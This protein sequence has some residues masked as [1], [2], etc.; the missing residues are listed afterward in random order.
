[1]SRILVIV[2]SPAKAIKIQKILGKNYIVKSSYGHIR[3]LDNKKF[4]SLGIDVN[5]NF[6]PHYINIKL[7]TKNINELKKYVKET[8]ETILAS[9]EDREGEAIAWHLA[10]VL[11]L[12]INKTKRICFNEITKPALLNAINNPKLINIDLVKAQKTRQI[13]DKLVGYSISPILCQ[14]IQKSL[15]AGRVQSVANRL[16]VER[17]NEINNFKSEIYYKTNGYFENDMIVSELNKKFKNKKETETFLND[18]KISIFLIKDINN[19]IKKNKPPAPFTTSTLQQEISRTLSLSPKH[20]MSIAQTLY[21]NGYITYHRTDSTVLSNEIKNKIKEF[22]INKYTNKYYENRNYKSKSVNSQEAHEAI[23]PT[24]I[25]L[26][27]LDKL[28]DLENKIY[29]LIWKR[30]VASQMKEEEIREWKIEISINIRKELF[31][32]KTEETIFLGYKILYNEQIKNNNFKKFKK[33]TEVIMS[34]II[35]TEKYTNNE[36][37]YTEGSLINKMEKLGIG[38][39]STYASIINIIQDRKYVEKKSIKGNEVN[40]EILSLNKNKQILISKD[41]IYLENEKNKLIPNKLGIEVNNYLINNFKNLFEYNFTCSVEKELDKISLGNNNDNIIKDIYNSFIIKVNELTN[42]N[43]KVS[44]KRHIGIDNNTKKNIY[45]YNAKYGPVIQIGDDKDT[46]KIYISIKDKFNI[47]DI[48]EEEANSLTLYP[49]DLGKYK[50]II[51][52]I[53]NGKYGYYISYDNNNYKIDNKNINLKDAIKYIESNN[54]ETSIIK[55]FN[56]IYVRNGKY[57]PYIN[58]KGKNISIPKNINI[59]NITREECNKIINK[60]KI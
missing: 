10:E 28:N 4:N 11:K 45:A 40:I 30:T 43:K 6:K 44:N 52:Y 32:G 42:N 21:E 18:C 56:N 35:S 29:T 22:I 48:T 13:I 37:R 17:E 41:K 9:D 57:G 33:N 31:I 27:K 5:N 3:N 19:K 8:S 20:I 50:N 59:N 26:I 60:K 25:N 7:R 34:K 1:M 36:G 54:I 16:I 51:V 2:E 23:R 15:S 53:K 58:Y 46:N 12:N 38:R 24:N 55:K 47:D 49:K 14:N 39:P